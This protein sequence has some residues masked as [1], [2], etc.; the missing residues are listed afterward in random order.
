MGVGAGRVLLKPGD[1]VIQHR[2]V[3]GVGHRPA[4][5]AVLMDGK[6]RVQKL[7]QL[8]LILRLPC[9]PAVKLVEA[10]VPPA[11]PVIR[12]PLDQ[13]PDPF[14]GCLGQGLLP[15]SPSVRLSKAALHLLLL[16]GD[17][18][19]HPPQDADKI[20]RPQRLSGSVQKTAGHIEPFR[21]LGQVQI[22]VKPLDIALLPGRG[23]K[24]QPAFPQLLPLHIRQKPRAGAGLRHTALIDAQEKEHLHVF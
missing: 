5:A 7:G 17:L 9:V 21:R 16:H 12:K 10:G 22:E 20:G 6:R 2:A 18:R 13:K 8:L 4:Q 24:L 14:P 1:A 11:F 3:E 23:R 19:E 15:G